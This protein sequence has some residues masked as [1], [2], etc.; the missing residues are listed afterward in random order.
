MIGPSSGARRAAHHPHRLDMTT[1]TDFNALAESI[2]GGAAF[3]DET[4]STV[5]DAVRE[6]LHPALE[7]AA[8]ANDGS[9]YDDLQAALKLVTLATKRI[10]SND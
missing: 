10:V 9:A 6:A 8:L 1:N 5:L 3:T 4:R 2:I 7:A